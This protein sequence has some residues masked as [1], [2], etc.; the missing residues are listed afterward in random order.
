[1]K[2]KKGKRGFQEGWFE[3]LCCFGKLPLCLILLLVFFHVSPF[4]LFSVSLLPSRP[5]CW[6]LLPPWGRGTQL[7]LCAPDTVELGPNLGAKCHPQLSPNVIFQLVW[8]CWSVVSESGRKFGCLGYMRAGFGPQRL[9]QSRTRKL[10]S[11]LGSV[12]R[13]QRRLWHRPAERCVINV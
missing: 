5:G 13:S 11:Y 1:M 10:N 8:I 7:H 6:S 12:M 2:T 3:Y 4:S 9:S